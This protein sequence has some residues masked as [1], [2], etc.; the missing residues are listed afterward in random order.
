M[1]LVEGDVH[2]EILGIAVRGDNALM[3]VHAERGGELPLGVL[4]R[5]VVRPVIPE[6]Q[7]QVIGLVAG[8][9][10]VQRLRRLNLGD[11]E[12]E[13]HGIDGIAVRAG[14]TSRQPQ[15]VELLALIA[16]GGQIARQPSEMIAG[17]AG[18]TLGD[19]SHPPSGVAVAG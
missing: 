3:P 2:M 5:G 1:H 12:L 10:G 18:D 16:G 15:P 8:G 7:D 9:A 6:R 13:I 11:G 14:I 17:G 4:Q 19:H